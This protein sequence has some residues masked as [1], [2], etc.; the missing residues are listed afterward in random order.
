[1]SEQIP[2]AVSHPR[3]ENPVTTEPI[4]Y[5]FLCA[6]IPSGMQAN[7]G[8]TFK[9]LEINNIE[10]KQFFLYGNLSELGREDVKE[11]IGEGML[12]LVT[13]TNLAVLLLTD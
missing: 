3:I 9:L 7:W 8:F 5:P 10:K 1:M 4:C 2:G 11:E 6:D 12:P 13:S